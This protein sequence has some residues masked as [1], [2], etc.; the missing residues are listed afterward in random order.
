MRTKIIA[1]F[2]GT[3]KTTYANKY[4]EKC[5]DSD[6]SQFSWS[7]DTDGKKIRNPD[8]PQNYMAHIKSLIGKVQYIFVS[9]HK[10][11]REALA[12]NCFYYYIIYPTRDQKEKFL[13]LYKDRG[14]PEAFVKLLDEKWEA[15]MDEIGD[16][17]L[18]SRL[19]NLYAN[20]NVEKEIQFMEAV[21]NGDSKS[22]D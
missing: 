21:E 9:T 19:I 22:E 6:S 17:P 10:E 20:S 1:A 13:Q 14:S 7:V 3:G 18:G 15:W 16:F 8:F 5:S 2:P 12:D 11:V 4:P